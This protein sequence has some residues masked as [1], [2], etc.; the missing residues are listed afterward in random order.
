MPSKHATKRLRLI[1]RTWSIILCP[2]HASCWHNLGNWQKALEALNTAETRVPRNDHG[3]TFMRAYMTGSR[4]L[5]ELGRFVDGF[6]WL[7]RALLATAS[8]HAVHGEAP[9]NL[10]LA[11]VE[12]K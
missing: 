1:R 10:N 2:W 8:R 12:M 6:Q 9:T 5:M 7:D 4:K 11:L 3:D